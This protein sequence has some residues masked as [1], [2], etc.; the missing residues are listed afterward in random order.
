MTVTTAAR[1]TLVPALDHHAG[2]EREL[3]RLV[4]T[5]K[6]LGWPKRCI[7][8]NVFLWEYSY[9]RLQLAQLLGQHGVFLTR[10]QHLPPGGRL[11]ARAGLCCT[12]SRS[13]LESNLAP[14]SCRPGPRHRHPPT[15]DVA[16]F[17]A[18]VGVGWRL[19]LLVG[20]VG[21]ITGGF[22]ARRCGA[23]HP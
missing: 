3:E 7:L 11:W 6:V 12:W 4:G 17:R 9:K 14:P 22:C 8:P 20:S 15:K 13:L 18:A 23:L 1:Q 21:R 5:R 16:Y 19:K 2:A 10:A